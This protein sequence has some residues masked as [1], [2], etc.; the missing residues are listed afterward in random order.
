M[1]IHDYLNLA[2][3]V[4]VAIIL[5]RNYRKDQ[6]EGRDFLGGGGGSKEPPAQR[7]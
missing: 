6:S 5:I 3:I 2:L 1:E 7:K 4:G